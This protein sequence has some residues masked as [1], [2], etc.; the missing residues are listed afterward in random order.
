V[1]ATA[2][3]L[4]PEATYTQTALA[5]AL[6]VSVHTLIRWRK[7]LRGGRRFPRPFF[8]GRMPCW[9]GRTIVGW[10]DR[11]QAEAEDVLS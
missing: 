9:R 10:Q 11:M 4:D 2:I 3:K 1:T 7:R 5:E 8:Q 6:G